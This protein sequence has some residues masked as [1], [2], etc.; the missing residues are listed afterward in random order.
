MQQQYGTQTWDKRQ[1]PEPVGNG[2]DTEGDMDGNSTMSKLTQ[3]G[4]GSDSTM[5]KE[6]PGWDSG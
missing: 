5:S 3:R 1:Q 4:H 2:R 6:W